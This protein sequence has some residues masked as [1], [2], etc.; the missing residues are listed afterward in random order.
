MPEVHLVVNGRA[1]SVDVHPMTRLLDVLRDDLGLTGTKEGCGE[2]ECGACAVLLDGEL[3]NS[4]LVPIGQVQGA[5]VEREDPVEVQLDPAA[6]RR[7][8][9]AVRVLAQ[10]AAVEHPRRFYRRRRRRPVSR[11]RRSPS[12]SRSPIRYRIRS[13][14]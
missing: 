13:R 1:A 10:E 2:G 6:R 12:T 7:G 5:A 3:A 14:R 11:K 8:A 9:H 4:C